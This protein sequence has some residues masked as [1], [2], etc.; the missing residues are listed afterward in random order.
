MVFFLKKNIISGLFDFCFA[1]LLGFLLSTPGMASL[2]SFGVDGWMM[3][4]GKYVKCLKWGF[5]ARMYEKGAYVRLSVCLSVCLSSQ[6]EQNEKV[7][8]F[9]VCIPHLPCP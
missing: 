9:I 3:G 8:Y 4:R 5:R 6:Q 2:Y 1:F 7:L